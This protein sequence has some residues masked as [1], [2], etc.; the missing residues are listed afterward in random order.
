MSPAVEV[1]ARAWFDRQQA[2]RRDA[3][4]LRPDGRL[5]QWEDISAQDQHTY[6]ALMAPVAEAVAAE[7]MTLHRAQPAKTAP[8]SGDV[9]CGECGRAWPCRTAAVFSTGGG[10]R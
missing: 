7:V 1:A 8:V 9:E 5:W 4:R 10:Q 3:A 2:D 6:R